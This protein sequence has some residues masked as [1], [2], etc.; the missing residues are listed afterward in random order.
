MPVCDQGSASVQALEQYNRSTII[1]FRAAQVKINYIES[2]VRRQKKCRSIA[3][4]IEKQP[5][6]LR[7]SSSSSFLHVFF[8]LNRK[9]YG[10]PSCC[11]QRGRAQASFHQRCARFPDRLLSAREA[12]RSRC[13]STSAALTSPHRRTARSCVDPEMI[14][15]F[16][17]QQFMKENV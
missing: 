9:K 1:I 15:K 16:R 4:S 10:A 14:P 8:G 6:F 2:S 12:S 7:P 17:Q 11:K 5:I 13:A 3:N